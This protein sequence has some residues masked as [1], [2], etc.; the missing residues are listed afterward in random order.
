MHGECSIKKRSARLA[1][2]P[3]ISPEKREGMQV[4]VTYNEDFVTFA[5]ANSKFI[6][7][8]E[9]MFADFVLSDKRTQVLPRMP[10]DQRKY[11]AAMYRMDTQMGDQEPHR[12]VQ[13]IRRIDTHIPKPLLPAS[14]ASPMPS[15]LGKLADLRA[16]KARV[17][18]YVTL[19]SV[20][21]TVAELAATFFFLHKHRQSAGAIIPTIA[22]QLALVFPRIEGYIVQAIEKDVLLLSSGKARHTQML[23]LVIKPLRILKFRHETPYSMV[24]DALDELL[25]RDE[26]ARF[27][28]LLINAFS[29]K[30]LPNIHLLFTS[31]PETHIIR[32]MQAGIFVISL[33]TRQE[34]AVEDVRR[35][36]RTSLDKLRAGRPQ[37]FGQPPKPWPSAD[38]FETLASQAGDLFVYAAMIVNFVSVDGHS[39]QQR[40]VRLLREKSNVDDIDDI[41][42]R[43]R[44][45]IAFSEN[46]VVHCQLLAHIIHLYEPLPLPGLQVLF[47]ADTDSLAVM[48][49]VFSAE[50][51]DGI[52]KVEIYH[53]SLRDFMVDPLRL[54]EYHVQ[55]ASAHEH[56][57]CCCLD[58][59]VR[60]EQIHTG[61]YNYALAW[62]GVHL[63]VADPSSKLQNLLALF[64]EGTL[65]RMLESD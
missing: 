18:T 53:S 12:S 61:A 51:P 25:P 62:W 34:G 30:D 22:Y 40:L 26:A 58:L 33:T 46:P 54:E 10:P 56:L 64:T 21:F 20:A 35:F 47:H 29:D 13:L 45:I 52:G 6:A 39:P 7:L 28:M 44:Q 1:D 50:P 2:A 38:E 24:I 27:I 4:K 15:V 49:E 41:D 65:Q 23:E 8:V 5:T 36:L 17:E 55:P 3:G 57:A 63:S 60:K 9:K 43:C 11:L 16:P 14:L 59:L 48:L 31:R 19:T 32:V 42:G 37:F